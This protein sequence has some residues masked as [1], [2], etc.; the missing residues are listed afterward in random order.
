MA[1]FIK[2]L[3]NFPEIT[4]F[5]SR[6]DFLNW[7]E[8]WKRKHNIYVS[9]YNKRLNF[10]AYDSKRFEIQSATLFGYVTK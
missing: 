2:V 9:Y 4:S 8:I 10:Y 3:S 7:I 5:T 1:N 6:N